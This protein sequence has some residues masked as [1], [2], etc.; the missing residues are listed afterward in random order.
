MTVGRATAASDRKDINA[1]VLKCLK[2]F[3]FSV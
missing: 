3:G 1:I 2:E